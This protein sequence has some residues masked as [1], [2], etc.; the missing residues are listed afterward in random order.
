MRVERRRVARVLQ[1]CGQPELFA[2]VGEF[3]EERPRPC[4]LG[5][6]LRGRLAMDSDKSEVGVAFGRKGA[7]GA[8]ARRWGMRGCVVVHRWGIA[9]PPGAGCS[10][11]R[12]AAQVIREEL[13][14]TLGG[15]WEARLFRALLRVAGTGCAFAVMAWRLGMAWGRGVFRPVAALGRRLDSRLRGN[16]GMGEGRGCAEGRGL[17]FRPRDGGDAFLCAISSGAC[18]QF[19]YWSLKTPNFS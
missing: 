8:G 16:D 17:L 1:R 2:C 14:R 10:E 6:R 13:Q 7:S 19:A 11:R 4:G 12:L 18:L 5:L 9:P 3:G 15:R